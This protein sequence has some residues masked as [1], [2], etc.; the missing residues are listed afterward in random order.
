MRSGYSSRIFEISSVPIPEPVPPPR[1]WVTWKP[2][3]AKKEEMS[4]TLAQESGQTLSCKRSE[5]QRKGGAILQAWSGKCGLESDCN[6]IDDI[7]LGAPMVVDRQACMRSTPWYTIVTYAA[8]RQE[9][10][11]TRN[12]VRAVHCSASMQYCTQVLCDLQRW[13]SQNS[14]HCQPGLKPLCLIR[15]NEVKV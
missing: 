5:R 8:T 10:G 2:A 13:R 7:Q 11:C 14:A 6:K 12:E 3:P 1:E 15:T 4:G 9:V